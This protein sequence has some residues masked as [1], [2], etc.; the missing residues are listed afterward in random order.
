VLRLLVRPPHSPPRGRAIAL[1]G[2]G[3]IA[4][5]TA[6]WLVELAMLQYTTDY[7]AHFAWVV[8]ELFTREF[9]H[10]PGAFVH[11]NDALVLIEGTGL[12]LC[13]WR[14]S[15]E[16][17]WLPAAI[18]RMTVVAAAA[19]AILNVQRV[20]Q[21]VLQRGADWHAVVT[22]VPSMRFSVLHTDV[23]A[24]G[25]YFVMTLPIA[26]GLGIGGRKQAWW[27]L[28]VPLLGAAIWLAGSRAAIAAGGVGVLWFLLAAV[29]A[30]RSRFERAAMSAA[31]VA[32]IA[33]IGFTAFLYPRSRNIPASAALDTRADMAKVAFDLFATRPVFGI[34]VG[35]FWQRS[36]D[37]MPARLK[38]FYVRENAHNNFLQILAELGVLGFALFLAVIAIATR[39]LRSIRGP[40]GPILGGVLAGLIAFLVTCLAGHPLLTR[41]VAYPFWLVI[42]AIAALRGRPVTTATAADERRPPLVRDGRAWTAALAVALAITVPFR[43]EH[44]KRSRNFENVAVGFSVWSSADDG[45]RFRWAQT[46]A[47]FFVPES[48]ASVLIPLRL[49]PQ[50]PGPAR[51]DVRLDGRHVNTIEVT[52]DRWTSV[53]VVLAPGR[54][55]PQYRR[56]ELNSEGAPDGALMVGR[57]SGS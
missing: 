54:R 24:A 51:V 36:A 47:R 50:A 1:A 20:A 49:G 4:V 15:P 43:V 31:L 41:E 44:E 12:A 37:Y 14:F 26:L 27:L 19:A 40:D 38:A 30:G 21:L 45:V 17:D 7:P 18:L 55:T 53:R 33:V 6:S 2:L 46:R 52:R 25:S 5:V 29:A 48:D 34:G 39:P 28:A 8:W 57:L 35:T 42:G 32:A 9:F 22:I 56:I 11:L 13:V 23:N 16:Q 10:D 3:F